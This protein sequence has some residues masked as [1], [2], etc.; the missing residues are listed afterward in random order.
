MKVRYVALLICVLS[1]SLFVFPMIMTD[2]SVNTDRPSTSTDSP[3]IP[4]R[5][6]FS[7]D[8]DPV[9]TNSLDQ[10]GSVSNFQYMQDT[11]D[12]DYATLS[13]EDAGSSYWE[14]IYTQNFEADPLSGWYV[15]GWRRTNTPSSL[16]SPINIDADDGGGGGST[17]YCYWTGYGDGQGSDDVEMYMTST[18][19]TSGASQVR[20]SVQLKTDI[21]QTSTY[22]A[23]Y[24]K[25]SGDNWDQVYSTTSTHSWFLVTRTSSDSQYLHPNFAVRFYF[26]W[27][28][29]GSMPPCSAWVD[30][31]D[32][33]RY[34]YHPNYRMQQQFQFTSVDYSTYTVENLN[35][36]LNS[37]PSEGLVVRCYDG[38]AWHTLGTVTS[39]TL[40]TF[41]VHSYLTSATFTVELVDASTSG[42]STQNEW[43][44]D[45][46]YLEIY[47]APPYNSATPSVDSLY[48]DNKLLAMKSDHSGDYVYIT[49]KHTDPDGYTDI[50]TC[51]LEGLIGGTPKWEV[52]YNRTSNTSSI[53]RG[54]SYIAVEKVD[55]S[56]TGTTLTLKWHIQIKWEHPETSDMDLRCTVA[57]GSA[58]DTDT[59]QT[60]LEVITSLVF[61]TISLNDHLGT[62]T[63]GDLGGTITASGTVYYYGTFEYPEDSQVDVW[64]LATLD[65]G[66]KS[67]SDTRVTT[68]QFSMTVD[69]DSVVG[70]TTYTFKV[71]KESNESDA[72]ALVS[73]TR[74][75]IT[76][77]INCTSITS[78]QN[79]V[80]ASATGTVQVR[81]QY[82]YD[83]SA[84][85]NGNYSINGYSLIHDSGDLWHVNIT[86]GTRT[87]LTLDS[88]SITSDNAHGVTGINMNSQ[89]LDMYWEVVDVYISAPIN[90]P[91]YV[92]ENA[93]GISA[94]GV[95]SYYALHGYVYY[96]GTLNLNNTQFAYDTVGTRGYRVASVA[97]DDAFGITTIRFYNETSCTWI[98]HPP[99]WVTQP[100]N[101][102]VELGDTFEYTLS[103]QA[104]GGIDTWWLNDT[105]H[106]DVN[107]LGVVS[108][109]T[110][111]GIGTYV[112]QVWLN[113]TQN[114]IIT[115]TFSVTVQDTMPPVWTE[116]PEDQYIESMVGL[117]YQLHAFDFS[118]IGGWWIDNTVH[119]A[120]NSTGFLTNATMLTLGSYEVTVFVNDTLGH[121]MSVSLTIYVLDKTLPT[122]AEEPVDQFVEYGDDL[123]YLLHVDAELGV[124]SWAIDDTTHFAVDEYGLVTSISSLAVGE[125]PVTVTVTDTLG[126]TLDGTFTVYVRDTTP[127]SWDETPQGV[128]VEFGTAISLQF[129]ATDLSGVH[130]WSVDD[131]ARFVITNRGWLLN[132]TPLAVGEYSLNI[133]VFDIY[134]NCRSVIIT[135]TVEP[136]TA[137]QLEFV[138]IDQII[139]L[140]EDFS[141]QLSAHDE[142]G[143]GGWGLNDTARFMI[144]GTGLIQNKVDLAVGSYGLQVWVSDIYGNTNYTTFTVFVEDTTPPIWTEAP[145]R[146][147]IVNEGDPVVIALHAS[148]PSLPLTWRVNDTERFAINGTGCIINRITLEAG[149]YW[150]GVNVTDAYG[151]SN[152]VE[153]A[154]IVLPSQYTVTPG[155]PV[156]IVLMLGGIFGILIIVLIVFKLP[157]ILSRNSASSGGV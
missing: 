5:Q 9:D 111:L 95:Y 50:E 132:R 90:D 62:A 113:N 145:P 119:F 135:I 105:V 14:S 89:S 43:Q 20:V 101:R 38:S 103:A 92:G 74:D 25:D 147:V 125:Y 97:G 155:Q 83:G 144:D 118:G 79:I 36:K 23:M 65:S 114:D 134:D 35:I 93:S 138:P 153:I 136:A 75:Y 140:G 141:Y 98:Y 67:W 122:W 157:D 91:I 148:D 45:A 22:F 54:A 11:G 129:S 53:N 7:A 85:I 49:T 117:H 40:R 70:L 63:R 84:V 146:T 72:P 120:I 13:E 137:P 69:A 64:V 130:Y 37:N 78:P 71:V 4:D 123:Y 31:L 142:S 131:T 24:F 133:S 77:R 27:L 68:G 127:P 58:S 46:L 33:S 59:Y 8:T 112:I 86:P 12:S 42:D 1:I 109:A 56:G 16:N 2:S 151:N 29:S 100:T 19:S 44:V 82:E 81:L 94:W 73:D 47:D 61:S 60:N 3:D 51:T 107:S 6:F 55:A 143:I 128:S 150:I 30:N 126:R 87:V 96:S 152:Y 18:V 124:S 32:I 99:E 10:Y 88:V 116:T 66:S 121:T 108:N 115:A 80:D 102:I 149:S 106:F 76:D 156:S 34:I 26:H 154:I 21:E 17:G 28:D 48:D 52:E 110:F 41:N 104:E 15:D 57:D 139:E 39:S